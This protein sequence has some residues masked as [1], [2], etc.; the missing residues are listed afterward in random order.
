MPKISA[1]IIAFNE[2]EKIKSALKSVVWADEIIVADSFSTDK[3]AEI[4]EGFG[5]RV[6]QVPFQGFGHLRNT[7]IA[8]CSHDW[9]F[10][11]DSDERKAFVL[12]VKADP[13]AA[14]ISRK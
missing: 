6:I 4:A 14:P 13:P 9:I 7:A 12:Q 3:T 8:A 10:S 11:L 5:A 1:Y 2:E